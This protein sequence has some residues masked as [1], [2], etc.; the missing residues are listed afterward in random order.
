MWL[1]LNSVLIKAHRLVKGH[2]EEQE[3]ASPCGIDLVKNYFGKTYSLKLPFP[4]GHVGRI[5]L[6]LS[7]LPN[8]TAGH[9]ITFNGTGFQLLK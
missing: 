8:S 4:L 7:L 3:D 5:S 9:Y 1:S 6:T 2:S